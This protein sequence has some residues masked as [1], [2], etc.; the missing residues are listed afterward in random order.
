MCV[1]CL[2]AKWGK[3]GGPCL[4]LRA[5]RKARAFSGRQSSEAVD[6]T[7]GR[8]LA[9]GQ[10]STMRPEARESPSS[11]GPAWN[12]FVLSTKANKHA[13][14]DAESFQVS[15]IRWAP[16]GGKLGLDR[17]VCISAA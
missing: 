4:G 11:S 9:L 6:T 1:L 15:N 10:A 13:L 14:V 12:N 2:N 7:R 8:S 5:R 16:N 3:F 17:R